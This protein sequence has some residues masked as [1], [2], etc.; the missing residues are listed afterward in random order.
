MSDRQGP[1]WYS[2]GGSQVPGLTVSEVIEKSD[3]EESVVICRGCKQV[4]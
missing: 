2:R 1:V 3:I 4:H